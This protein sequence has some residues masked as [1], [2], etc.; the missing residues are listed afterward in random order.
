MSCIHPVFHVVKL[1]P[2]PDDPI[3]GRCTNPPPDPVLVDG[4]EE[5]KVEE[6]MNSWFFSR[7]LQFLVAWK[8]YG[9]EEWSW[10]NKKDLHTPE[11]TNL[12]PYTR[13]C[14]VT[15]T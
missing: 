15:R 8:G 2:T 12:M 13:L 4:E 10:V 3:A 14:E 5:Y 6:I 9:R 11:L 1:K 7:K